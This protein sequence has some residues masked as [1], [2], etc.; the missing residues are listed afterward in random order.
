MTSQIETI[1]LS[2][3]KIYNHKITWDEIESGKNIRKN[4]FSVLRKKILD[5]GKSPSFV[6]IGEYV[7]DSKEK[8]L[9][10]GYTEGSLVNKYFHLLKLTTLKTQVD[11]LYNDIII[12]KVPN[13]SVLKYN[14]TQSFNQPLD[15]LCF[16]QADG[17]KEQN[18][19]EQEKDQDDLETNNDLED[20]VGLDDEQQKNIY[21]QLMTSVNEENTEN[22]ELD[23]IV[24]EDD[25]DENV[26]NNIKTTINHQNEFT[27]EP[28]NYSKDFLIK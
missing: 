7:L 12:I 11:N 28:Y 2:V 22:E 27:E 3:N 24:I 10:Y 9:F 18:I 23:T 19:I 21:N 25:T 6:L 14:Q 17:Q 4:N 5:K 20:E 15:D 1:V 8:L 26:N 16:L 13:V